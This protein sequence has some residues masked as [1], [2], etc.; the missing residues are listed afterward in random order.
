MNST[1]KIICPIK[2]KEIHYSCNESHKLYIAE[3]K[4]TELL[5]GNHTIK[6]IKHH[7]YF[8]SWF[9]DNKPIEEFLVIDLECENETLYIFSDK[10]LE[11]ENIQSTIGFPIS[12]DVSS[13][14]KINCIKPSQLSFYFSEERANYK[15]LTLQFSN[16]NY[17]KVY[18]DEFKNGI[19]IK[20]SRTNMGLFNTKLEMDNIF[21][22]SSGTLEVNGKI[23]NIFET[24]KIIINETWTPNGKGIYII[25]DLLIN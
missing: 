14:L 18:L 25:N 8:F 24:D 9:I 20:D 13:P 3:N 7:D 22:Y 17:C 6:I 15:T 21:T 10:R 1:Y 19:F 16:E 12:W 5:P 4:I 23:Y 11:T 2:N